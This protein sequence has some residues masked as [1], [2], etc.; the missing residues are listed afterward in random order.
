MAMKINPVSKI[1]GLS[2]VL[3]VGFLMVVLAAA[4]WGN[5]MP[6]VSALL[7][8]TAHLPILIINSHYVY[9]N[10]LDMDE[11]GETSGATD[12]GHFLESLL[13]T[14][15]VALPLSLL[16]CHTM[17]KQASILTVLGGSLIYGTIVTF[18]TFFDGFKEEDD[19]FGF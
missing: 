12:V 17:T 15:A 16:H 10:S 1:I 5:W 13:L 4:V 7:F 19:P 9:D 14:S 6:I 18:T 3:A 2:S 11:E 8:A